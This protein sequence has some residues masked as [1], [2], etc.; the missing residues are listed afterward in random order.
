MIPLATP[1]NTGDNA[2]SQTG[3]AHSAAAALA[4]GQ[5]DP[6]LQDLIQRWPNVPEAVRAGILAMVR[7]C[8]PGDARDG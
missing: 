4:E 8:A 7:Q 6:D 2:H 5:S 3:A 1:K